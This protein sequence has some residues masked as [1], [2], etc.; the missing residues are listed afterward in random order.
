MLLAAAV[1]V[2]ALVVGAV[3]AIG[4]GG[5]EPRSTATK[6]AKRIAATPAASPSDA[7]LAGIPQHGLTLGKHSAPATLLEFADPQ[8]PYCARWSEEKFPV[9]VRRFVKTGRLRLELRGLHFVGPDSE[10]ALRTVLAA[11][12]QDKAWNM[13]EEL[14][15]RQGAEN[16]GW[17][18]DAVLR[19]AATAAG[20]DVAKMTADAGSPRVSA[21]IVES[22]A[23]ASALRVPGTP[24]FALVRPPAGPR[25]LT[26]PSL[27][28]AD[29]AASL[30]S[31]L[32]T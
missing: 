28:P 18:T 21:Q 15:A 14:Y 3:V 4:A 1:V 32:G 10:R 7:L 29:F 22:D 2:A 23:A 24:S 20:V 12:L 8:C 26:I 27:A 25:L 30:A 31:N 9:V 5:S 19:E 17:V 6:T 11:G 16:S 13:L